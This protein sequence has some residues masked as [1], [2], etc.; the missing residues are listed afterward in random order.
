MCQAQPPNSSHLFS[1]GV[2]KG[3]FLEADFTQNPHIS[4][5]KKVESISFLKVSGIM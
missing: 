3:W 5:R 2:V 4:T 1:Q